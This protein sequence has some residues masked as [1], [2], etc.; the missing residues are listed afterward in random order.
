MLRERPRRLGRVLLRIRGHGLGHVE[1]RELGVLG[2]GRA[3]AA[4]AGLWRRRRR[5]GREGGVGGGVGG[6]GGLAAVVALGQVLVGGVDDGEGVGARVAEADE[7]DRRAAGRAVG[8]GVG[9]VDGLRAPVVAARVGAVDAE[10][11]LHERPQR[12]D[13]HGRDRDAVLDRAQDGDG[14]G[15]VC[16]EGQR[17][18]D[19]L[20]TIIIILC[21]SRNR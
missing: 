5:E 1:L 15:I 16:E 8:G 6:G 14:S 20:E 3:G 4:A 7:L 17:G 2:R 19:F 9:R 13:A 12:G 10:E 21:L 11:L 18:V